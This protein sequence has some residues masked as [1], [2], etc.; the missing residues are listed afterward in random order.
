MSSDYVTH[1]MDPVIAAAFRELCVQI[2]VHASLIM[3]SICLYSG[4]VWAIGSRVLRGRSGLV[5]MSLGVALLMVM[6]LYLVA[7]YWPS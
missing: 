5:G 6:D 1:L 7:Q 2:L 4:A 3:L